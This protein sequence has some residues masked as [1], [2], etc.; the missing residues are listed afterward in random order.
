VI[1]VRYRDRW[2]LVAD[3]PSGLPTQAGREGGPSLYGWVGDQVP[4]AGLHHRLDQPAS[5]LVLFTL[6]AA[7][8][9]PIARGFRDHTIRRLYAAVL[10]G[11]VV[12]T[13]WQRPIE[14]QPARTDVRV[15]GHGQGTTAAELRLHTGRTHQ[16]RVHAAMAGRP[17]LGDRRHGGD[18]G[19][20]WPRLALH[21][22]SLAFRHPA[23][24]EQ[25]TVR[26]PIPDD[27]RVLWSSAG[28]PE[29]R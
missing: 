24:G 29:D 1:Q 26:S 11:D 18:A 5:G 9:E 2:L 7:I 3:K 10:D 23:T 28:G 20:R 19:R 13:T 8:N 27:L 21:A 14:R 6:D 25:L 15:L 12:D 4:Y 22:R 17:V 16:I